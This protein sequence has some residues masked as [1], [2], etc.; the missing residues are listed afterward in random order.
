MSIYSRPLRER[1]IG[2]AGCGNMGLP[3]AMRLVDRGFH[4]RG[5][6]IR[7]LEEFGGFRQ[8]MCADPDSFRQYADI[9][10]SVVRDAQ[11]NQQLCYN[12][13]QI[14]SRQP[15]PSVLVVCSTLSPQQFAAIDRALPPGVEALDAPMSGAR[16]A[17]EAGSLTFM[18]GAGEE[19]VRYLR[20]LFEA[21]GANI[22]HTGQPGSGQAVKV[23]NNYVAATTVV[24]VRKV[25]AAAEAQRIDTD[26]LLDAMSNSSGSTW[27]G[28]R[29][30]HIDWRCEGYHKDNTIGILEKDVKCA[31]EFI[32][33]SSPTDFFD[34]AL[35][36]ALRKLPPESPS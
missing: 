30:T 13:Q 2:V 31:L 10:I 17:A 35:L 34:E 16:P 6:D 29:Y 1:R 33:E 22:V 28:N 9:M 20:P 3:M 24:A 8:H 14:F 7:P 18:V 25:L 5:Y 12:D 36:E 4:V 23:L 19:L 11:Q 21:M 26:M 27:F 15:W 32:R